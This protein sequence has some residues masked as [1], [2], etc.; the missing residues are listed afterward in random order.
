[1][2]ANAPNPE[3]SPR[4]V[5]RRFHSSIEFRLNFSIHLAPNIPWI[6]FALG[7]I[8]VAALGVWAYWFVI[9]PLPA[10]AHR[11]LPALRIA[12]LAALLWLLA[13]P[14]LERIEG[15]GGR[16]VVLLDRSRSMELPV[17]EGG[18]S[19]VSVAER[20]VEQLRR[21]G[22]GVTILPFAGRL[23][24]DSARSVEPGS[25]ALGDVLDAFARSAD[26]EQAGAVVVVSD[27]ATNA[28][29][30]PAEAARALG[31]PVHVVVVGEGGAM[32]RAIAGIDASST[33]QVG[34]AMLVRA[35][36]T[37]TEPA[38]STIP[39]VL[40]DRDRE[41]GRAIVTA[42]G[43]GAE[44]LAEFRVTPLQ[45]GL[46]VWTASVDSLSG[47]I[48]NAN[49]ARQVAVEV[50]PVKLGVVLISGGLNWDF[51]F[52]SRA[53]AGDSS[54]AVNSWVRGRD[55]WIAPGRPRATGP[56]VETL[57]GQA[58]VVLD[59]IASREVSAAF[60]QALR[61]FV[62]NGG[63]VM[64]FGG[65]A[66][67]VARLASGAFARDL[68]FATDAHT[69]TRAASPEPVPEARD[70]VMWD[71][72]PARGERAW[73]AA[74]PLEDLSPIAAGA[75]DRVLVRSAGNGPPLL[76]VRHVG[77]GQAL[78]VNG[79]GVWRWSLSG[80]DELSGER[81]RRLWRGLVHALAEP[82]QGEPL[83]V[84]PERWLT[85][86]GE[87]ARV[88]ATLQDEAFRPVAGATV[89][90][91]LRDAAGR[92]RAITYAPGSAGSYVANLED[93]PPGRY[94]VTARATRG[95]RELG[96]AASELGIDRWSLEQSRTLPD[97]AALAAVAR[98]SGG[99]VMRAKD[100]GHGAPLEMRGLARSR[101]RS[102]RLWES[103]W[104]FAVI[105]SALSLE[106]AWR[107]RRGLP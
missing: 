49:N 84:R 63:A 75:G 83:R 42:P 68:A 41:L 65:P 28:G 54:L 101:T 29:S 32:D 77:R 105:V 26:A 55:G 64:A 13:Q 79:T 36:V 85:S 74:A 53:L 69:L 61:A 95:G 51:A 52:V 59:A 56:G 30:D 4:L 37:T 96:R 87:T 15:S 25:T 16:L 1:M 102:L 22:R 88:F 5:P 90:G 107:R 27:G 8:A 106:W 17:V 40:R 100:L 70:L 47:E 66:P 93:L 7:T 46:A 18:A 80:T 72:D 62:A 48:T 3:L 81:G 82:V 33:A 11:A 97:S 38:G 76:L 98:A 89:E 60:D 31:L 58:V 43:S 12:A 10:I 35:R 50:A 19:R 34:R 73:R 103:P 14:V 57:R 92:T 99:R 71:D 45:S 67:G 94:R 86:A 9:P 20:A 39:V 44:A 2:S 21:T 6:L 78:V 91:E 24:A 23:G 104:V